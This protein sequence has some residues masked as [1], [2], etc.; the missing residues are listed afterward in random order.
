MSLDVNPK[1]R[2]RVKGMKKVFKLD[3]YKVILLL[4][5]DGMEIKDA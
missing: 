2:R 1:K 4:L 5:E 3:S